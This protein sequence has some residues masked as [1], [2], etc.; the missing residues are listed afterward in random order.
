MNTA[1][2]VIS[3]KPG[4]GCFFFETRTVTLCIESYKDGV[5]RITGL[6][7]DF[8]KDVIWSGCGCFLKGS[9]FEKKLQKA[10]ETTEPLQTI[11]ENLNDELAIITKNSH[12]PVTIF[13]IWKEKAIRHM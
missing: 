12:D 3:I 9:N 2:K 13:Q 1:T 10:F 11:E 6:A 7:G 8:A 5:C 4:K